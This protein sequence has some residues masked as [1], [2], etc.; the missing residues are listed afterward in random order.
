MFM[1]TVDKDDGSCV[2]IYIYMYVCVTVWFRFVY[3]FIFF[4]DGSD[5]SV[6]LDTRFINIYL[7]KHTRNTTLYIH[8]YVIYLFT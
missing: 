8:E 4:Y 2:C 7:L 1:L 6:I 3:L 5:N